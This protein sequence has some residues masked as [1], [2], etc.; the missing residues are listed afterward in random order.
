MGEQ[1]VLRQTLQQM[2]HRADVGHAPGG[3][4]RLLHGLHRIVQVAAQVGVAHRLH[5][6]VMLG[7]PLAGAAVQGFH[8]PFPACRQALGEEFAEQ[9]V[10]AVPGQVVVG[11]DAVD[12]QVLV[13]GAFDQLMG[14]RAV[15]DEPG[16]IGIEAPEQRDLLHERDQFGCQAG[17]HVLGQ[18]GLQ[19]VGLPE[20]RTQLR[21]LA[22]AHPQHGGDG[23]QAGRPTAGQVVDQALLVGAELQRAEVLLEEVPRF[24]QVERQFGEIDLGHGPLHAQPPQAERRRGPRGDGDMQVGRAMVQQLLQQPVREGRLHVMEVIHQQVQLLAYALHQVGHQGDQGVVRLL[25]AVALQPFLLDA[26]AQALQ[27]RQQ[28]GEEACEL[29]VV[30]AEGDPGHVQP[31]LHQFQ[32]PL[33]EQDG[34]AKACPPG[35][36]RCAARLRLAQA[37]QQLATDNVPSVQARWRELGGDQQI[38]GVDDICMHY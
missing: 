26:D 6:V 14:A 17:H 31:G 20:D 34:L 23:L 15:A 9:R 18:V 21:A 5:Q 1:D 16:E 22:R 33:R 12:Q 4:G 10:E 35:N 25:A 30:E 7:E 24:V 19:V 32:T 8:L 28:V 2:Q 3:R 36:Q 37:A 11:F 29:A 27:G 13:L 38:A